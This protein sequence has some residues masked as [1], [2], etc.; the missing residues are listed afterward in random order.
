MTFQENKYILVR[1]VLNDMT[2]SLLQY[3]SKMLEDVMCYNNNTLPGLFPFGDPQ[4]P[5]SFSYYGAL[6]TESLL[7][8]LKPV[9]EAHVGVELLPTYSY[10]RVYYKDAI[11]EKHTDR[12]SC[13]YSAT[14][15]IQCDKENP[16]PI[17][18]HSNGLDKSLILNAG[19]L[20]IYKGDEL[21]HWRHTCPYDNHIQVFLHFVGANGPFAEFK[22]DKRPKLGIRK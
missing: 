3:Q 21:P 8:L 15:C 9:I 14:L 5:N 11:L 20:C 12:I 13:E 16:W 6:F 4:S 18:F 2:I 10:M 1:D 17:S 7:L 19:D 22:F